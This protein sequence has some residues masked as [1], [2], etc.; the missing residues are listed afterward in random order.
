[1]LQISTGLRAVV[2]AV[3]EPCLLDGPGAILAGPG[4]PHISTLR[5]LYSEQQSPWKLSS[6]E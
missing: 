4:D 3:R 2:T 1:M 6:R 5:K